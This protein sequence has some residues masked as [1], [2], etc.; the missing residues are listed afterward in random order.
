MPYVWFAVVCLIWG[1]SFILM[2]RAMLCL[3]PVSIGAWRDFGGAAVLA[4]IFLLA[5]RRSHFRRSDLLPLLG[6]AVLGFAWPHSIQPEL[7][8]RIGMAFVGM[9]VGMTPLLTILVSVPMLGVLPTPRQVFGIVGALI[10]MAV[11]MGD[12][13]SHHV[14][15]R[16]LLLALS[17]PLTYSIANC[18]IR[19]SLRHL[20]P[21]EL[22]L[23]CLLMAGAGCLIP[24]LRAARVAPLEA[25]TASA[26]RPN[27]LSAVCPASQ[28]KL[29]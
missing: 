12:G 26:G 18:W 22:T 15:L 16:D 14:A 1:S 23:L 25:L 21:L 11:L 9:T 2:K 20:P 17:V 24:A 4:V 3:S 28:V 29:V 10:C 13:L 8:G 19:R 5:R 27:C 6:V 7:V